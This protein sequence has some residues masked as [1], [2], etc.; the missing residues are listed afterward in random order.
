MIELPNIFI[1]FRENIPK[2]DA[3]TPRYFCFWLCWWKKNHSIDV[4][5]VCF[6]VWM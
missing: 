1:C 5:Q 4:W 3:Y 2:K 6:H